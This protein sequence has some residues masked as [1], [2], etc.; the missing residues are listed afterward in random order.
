MTKI[1][2]TKV[3]DQARK[4]F[5]E[6]ED[7]SPAFKKSFSDLLDVVSFLSNR[8][9]MNSGNSSK[10]PSQDP[11]RKRSGKTAKGRKRKP[12]G[13]KGHKG[14]CLKPVE[15]PTESEDSTSS[16]RPTFAVLKGLLS[17]CPRHIIS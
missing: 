8:L 2:L 9:G 6:D 15:K 17:S 10:P 12:G 3:I 7:A 13:Q 16:N 14:N 5:D 4:S 1:K 11:N